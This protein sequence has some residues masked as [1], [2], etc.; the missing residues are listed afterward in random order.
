VGGARFELPQS[1]F[2]RRGRVGTRPSK[3]ATQLG[4]AVGLVAKVVSKLKATPDLAA[5]KLGEALDEVAK[6][7]QVVDQA[8]VQF[9]SLGIDQ[10]V[11][12]RN[13]HA[14]LTIE[15]GGL[16]T[17]VERG[18]GHCHQIA[19]VYDQRLDK[20]FERALS[21]DYPLIRDLFHRLG[22]ADDDVFKALT[23]VAKDLED[24]ASEILNSSTRIRS[25]M[26]ARRSWPREQRSDRFGRAC[27]KRCRTC[28]T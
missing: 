3:S 9:L 18:R 4:D 17:A 10:G 6:T 12:E 8:A 16:T 14:L 28:I 22:N 20:W 1:D 24:E 7:L 15:G 19:N 11:L 27:R 13:S 26:R 23:D 2:G 5:E 25:M 21:T